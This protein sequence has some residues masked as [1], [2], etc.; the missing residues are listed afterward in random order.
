MSASA[1]CFPLQMPVLPQ[2]AEGAAKRP[3]HPEARRRYHP[4]NCG[5][6]TRSRR[7]SGGGASGWRC[8][9]GRSDLCTGHL[10]RLSHREHERPAKGGPTSGVLLEIYRRPDLA[11]AIL[12][13][14]KTIA[15]GFKTNLFTSEGRQPLRWALSPTRLATRLPCATFPVPDTPSRKSAIAKRDTLPT[16]LMPSWSY[17]AVFPSMSSRASLITL[18]P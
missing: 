2:R 4:E 12:M 1:S 3:R 11:E 17:A 15:Q 7:R 5:L 16:S 18:N 10:C 9:F 14:N 6:E 8:C 13:P